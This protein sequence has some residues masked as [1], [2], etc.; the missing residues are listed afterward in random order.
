MARLGDG[1]KS[2]KL[3]KVKSKKSKMSVK[4][5]G[6]PSAVQSTLASF[7]PAASSKYTP[8][9]SNQETGS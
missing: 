1:Y 8:A 7:T 2:A 3:L 6:S 5:K 4:V 9:V